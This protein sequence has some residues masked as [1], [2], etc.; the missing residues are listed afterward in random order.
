MTLSEY[1]KNTKGVGVLATS[2]SDGRVDGAI[3]SR[4]HFEDEETVTFIMADRLSHKN[5]E[6]N[7]H[8]AYIFKAEEEGYTGKR[9]FL[10]KVKEED[11][12]A[13][14]N[15]LMKEHHP[16]VYEA[17]KDIKKFLVFFKIDKV[18]PLVGDKE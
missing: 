3:Y 9:L 7:A 10:T 14:I 6:S 13:V 8:A 11:D 5:L 2:D 16:D 1:F 4:P 15:Q 12:A 18:L 17:Y